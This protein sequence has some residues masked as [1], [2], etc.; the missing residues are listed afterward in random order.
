M[1]VRV[2]FVGA[3]GMNSAHMK[4]LAQIRGVEIVAICDLQQE[5]A[6]ERAAEY[7]A[8]SYTS[9]KKMLK[10]VPMDAMYVAVPPFAHEG[11][12]QAAAKLGIHLFVEKPVAVDVKTARSV[13]N[14][15]RKAGVIAT[16]GFQD[17]YQ[18]IVARMKKL[19]EKNQP[20]LIMGYWIG[21]MPGVPWWRVKAQSGGQAVEQ[22]IHT[23]D[24]ARNL[25]GEV[26]TVSATFSTGLMTDVPDYDVEDASCANLQFESGLCG[27]IFSGCFTKGYSKVG[28]DIWCPTMKI[29]YSGRSSLTVTEV[30]KDPVTYNVGNNFLLEIDKTFIKAV[31]KQDQSLLRS[32]YADACRSLAVPL[33]ANESMENGG[34]VVKPAKFPD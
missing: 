31:K 34:E 22:T 12:E 27:T 11:Q 33:A 26:K 13:N 16:A 2:G 21:G 30:G 3:G 28:L 20:A 8:K 4:N 14:A 7:G 18:D 15:I 25:F 6:D 10:D 24:M 32:S 1:A 29:E 23:F 17:R 19:L 5:R 9:W